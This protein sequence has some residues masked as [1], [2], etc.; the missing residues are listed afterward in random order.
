MRT[1]LKQRQHEVKKLQGGKEKAIKERLS[2]L[3]GQDE[4]VNWE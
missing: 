1:E 3:V 4:K 2:E